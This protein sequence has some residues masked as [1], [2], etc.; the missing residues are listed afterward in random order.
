MKTFDVY[1]YKVVGELKVRLSTESEKEAKMQACL[2]TKDLVFEPSDCNSIFIASPFE[3][4]QSKEVKRNFLVA[5]TI[6]K[7]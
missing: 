5:D 3:K 1:V 6:E 4:E 7:K 2:V